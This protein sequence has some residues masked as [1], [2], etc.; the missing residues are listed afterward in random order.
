[1][2]LCFL[3][4]AALIALSAVPGAKAADPYARQYGDAQTDCGTWTKLRNDP[5]QMK[6]PWSENLFFRYA[7]WETGFISGASLVNP[8]LRTTSAPEII[9]FVS[10][11]CQDHPHDSL[12]QAGERFLEVL[13]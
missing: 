5:V 12:Q 7:S 6:K 4:S 13:Q 3:L 9:K 8:R 10:Q 11:Y 2:R 1:M